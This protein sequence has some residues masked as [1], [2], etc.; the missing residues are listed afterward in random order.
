MG[1]LKKHFHTK[2]FGPVLGFNSGISIVGPPVMTAWC[3]LVGDVLIDSGIRH[4]REPLIH[5]LESSKPS[6]VLITHYHEDHSGNAGIIKD[7]FGSIVY[8][9]PETADIVRTS[10]KI[11]PY[12]HLVWGK[13]NPIDMVPYP[14]LIQSNTH[15]FKPIHTPGHSHDHT[16]YLEESKGWLF[17]GDLFLGEKIK[18]FR[19]DECMEDQ[20]HSLRHILTYEF[21]DLFCAHRPTMGTGKQVIAAKLD[22][23]LTFYGTVKDLYD[24]GLKTGEII[25]RLDPVNDR[26]VKLIT[27]NNACFAN[28]TRSALDLAAKEHTSGPVI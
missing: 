28:M 17:S 12:Q 21:S 18:F 22:F 27:L 3:Y 9:H 10:F 6:Q 15:T 4:V 20:I 5:S 24:Q 2:S 26:F 1:L 13:S 16:V 7:R 14:P 11:K 19:A 8:G 23:L 25:R